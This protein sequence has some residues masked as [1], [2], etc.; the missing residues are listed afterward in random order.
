M[1][2]IIYALTICAALFCMGCKSSDKAVNTTP[3]SIEG[4]S[5]FGECED[6]DTG[7]KYEVTLSF[8]DNGHCTWV[9]RDG[10]GDVF[11]STDYTYEYTMPNLTL[12]AMSPEEEGLEVV[13]NGFVLDKDQ[14][15][16]NG[17]NVYTIWL[18][19]KHNNLAA[20]LWKF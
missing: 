6:E 17:Y 4:T 11:S 2:R 18:Y 5:W 13:Y 7:V 10:I 20:S 16:M 9:L 15:S 3:V 12:F 19:D 1:N 8:F 14:A